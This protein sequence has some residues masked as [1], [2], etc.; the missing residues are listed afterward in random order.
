MKCF[1]LDLSQELILLTFENHSHE[2]KI[3]VEIWLGHLYLI[4]RVAEQNLKSLKF[5]FQI[6]S[7]Y[8]KIQMNITNS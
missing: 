7:K 4:V 1:Q 6:T 8:Q 5:N 3:G 2:A